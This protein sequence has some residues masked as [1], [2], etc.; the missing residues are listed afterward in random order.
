M[1]V[2]REVGY[3]Y[4]SSRFLVMHIE[5]GRYVVLRKM[6]MVK[7]EVDNEMAIYGDSD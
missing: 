6:G 4:R 7:L 5:L 1:Q 3:C 2:Q